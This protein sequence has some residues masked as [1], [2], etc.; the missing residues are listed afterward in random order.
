M[1][2][3]AENSISY[4]LPTNKLRMCESQYGSESSLEKES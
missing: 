2:L 4:M 3:Y 1:I